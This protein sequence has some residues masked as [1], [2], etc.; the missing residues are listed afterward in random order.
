MASR[1]SPTWHSA[2]ARTIRS[3]LRRASFETWTNYSAQA[4][5]PLQVLPVA[6]M[7]E[8]SS[9]HPPP[10]RLTLARSLQAANPL[11]HP[12]V[13]NQALLGRLVPPTGAHYNR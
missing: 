6:M 8:H 2:S 7:A 13:L 9:L 5:N 12:G 1:N 3:K 11:R 4:L 10:T